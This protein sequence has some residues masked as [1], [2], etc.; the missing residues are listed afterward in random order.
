[1]SD[2]L[3]VCDRTA[4]VSGVNKSAWT[5]FFDACFD[6]GSSLWRRSLVIIRES[7]TPLPLGNLPDVSIGRG[8]GTGKEFYPWNAFRFC[9]FFFSSFYAYLDRVALSVF[10]TNRFLGVVCTQHRVKTLRRKKKKWESLKK[11]KM[12]RLYCCS[13]CQ[14]SPNAGCRPVERT[15]SCEGT[16]IHLA[17]ERNPVHGR[18]P[19]PLVSLFRRRLRPRE[20]GPMA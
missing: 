4:L 6:R 10:S 2:Y 14:R 13:V 5:L 17:Q 12:A 8:F 3:V 20:P 16:R 11:K 1:M 7:L 15:V 18:S 9:F 19:K